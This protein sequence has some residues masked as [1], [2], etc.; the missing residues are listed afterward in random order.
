MKR[1]LRLWQRKWGYKMQVY[2]NNSK[3][4]TTKQVEWAYD[5]WCIGYTQK[6][7]GDALNVCSKTIERALKGRQ[8]IRPILK[9]NP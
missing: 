3:T 8:R 6:Q 4:L 7:I 2:G 9:Y 5:M 1:E